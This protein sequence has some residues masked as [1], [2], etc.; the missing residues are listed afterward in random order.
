MVKTLSAYIFQC[1]NTDDQMKSLFAHN[2]RGFV[3]LLFGQMLRAVQTWCI[4][5]VETEMLD[6]EECV[7]GYSNDPES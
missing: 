2:L 7:V 1:N 6:H 3:D 5:R 4:V